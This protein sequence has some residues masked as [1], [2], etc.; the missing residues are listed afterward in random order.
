MAGERKSVAAP[1]AQALAERAKA[2]R[3]RGGALLRYKWA[4]GGWAARWTGVAQ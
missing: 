4:P 1:Q 2:A 3:R